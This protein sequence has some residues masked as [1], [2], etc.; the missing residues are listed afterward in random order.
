[1]RANVVYAVVGAVHDNKFSPATLLAVAEARPLQLKH[2]VTTLA[3]V[4]L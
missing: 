1:M 4:Y 3:I 2:P